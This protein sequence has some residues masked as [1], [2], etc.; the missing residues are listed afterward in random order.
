MASYS[1]VLEKLNFNFTLGTLQLRVMS[2]NKV[3]PN[4]E[5][6]VPDHVHSDY[7]FHIIPE[8]RGFINIEG[9]DFEVNGGEFYIT[10]PM[11][12]HRQISDKENPMTEYCLECEIK[13]LKDPNIENSFVADESLFIKE[14]LSKAYP[15]SF[16]D[17][18]LIKGIIENI[19]EEAEDQSAGFLMKI[20]LMVFQI[21]H[22]LF[23]TICQSENILYDYPTVKNTIDAVR[24]Q[25]LIKYIDANYK[26]H[27]NLLD[28][29]K[30]LLLSPRQ[31]DRL[32]K[33]TFNQTFH[34]YLHTYRMH[35]AEKLLINTD[36]TIEEIAYESGFSSH[37]YMYQ[38]FKRKGLEPPG[39][40]RFKR[41][42]K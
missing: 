13:V 41:R 34:D 38:A 37:Y 39:Y 18:F 10:G 33:K 9:T 20:Q 29:S 35:M 11:I 12:C 16:K 4:P 7:E 19:F 26:N 28:V 1:N 22:C 6:V 21:I 31:I 27:I 15:R 32:M 17:I 25:R 23:R 40:F 8:G 24:I 42:E 36:L 2:L 30:V 14:V 5:W 3:A